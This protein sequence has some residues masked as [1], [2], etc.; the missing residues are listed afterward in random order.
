MFVYYNIVSNL[1]KQIKINNI[2]IGIVH[3]FIIKGFYT[4]HL[5]DYRELQFLQ[6]CLSVQ[7]ARVG[8]VDQNYLL[9]HLNQVHLLFLEGLV[10]LC[11]RENQVA[12]ALLWTLRVQ[13]DLLALVHLEFR[14][15]HLLLSV[16]QVLL[17]PLIKHRRIKRCLPILF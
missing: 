15:H 7:Q 12:R 10:R 9:D 5:Q 3:A 2:G 16:Q 14:V 17:V 6:A 1:A 11:L 8:L 4:R 13:E